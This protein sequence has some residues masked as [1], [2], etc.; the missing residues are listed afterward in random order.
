MNQTEDYNNNNKIV[1]TLLPIFTDFDGKFKGRLSSVIPARITNTSENAPIS[2]KYDCRIKVEYHKDIM[3]L[4]EEGMVIAIRNFKGK[5]DN[6][7]TII[8]ETNKSKPVDRFTLLVISRIWPDHYGIRGLA[9]STYYPMQFEV[10]EQ[11]V[12]DWDTDDKATMMIQLSTIPINYDLIFYEDK[13]YEFVKGF[14]YPIIADEVFLLHSDTIRDM[15]NKKIIEQLENKLTNTKK[16]EDVVLKVADQ[17][18]GIIKMFENSKEKIPIY[19]N[20]DNMIRYHFGIFSFTGGGKSNLLSNLLRKILLGTEDTKIVIFDISCEYPFLLMDIFN[21]PNIKSQIILESE[22]K[23]SEQFDICVVKPR[24]YED[25]N[26]V[27]IALSKVYERGIVSHF[28]KP[29]DITPTYKQIVDELNELKAEGSGKPH[30]ISAIS[31][32]YKTIV[33]F[34]S[35]NELDEKDFINLEFVQLMS[36]EAVNIMKKYH[37]HDKSTIYGWALSLQNLINNIKEAKEEEKKD[38]GFTT[39]EIVDTI[40]GDSRLICISISDPYKIKELAI[41]ISR[42]MLRKRKRQFK[43]RPYVLFVFDEAQEFIQDLSNSKGIDKECSQEIETLLRQGRK[44]GLGGCIATQR[45]AYLNTSA[46]QQLHTYF[47]GTLP[48]PYDR[49]VVSST[50]TIDQG[51]L[52]K[53]LEFAPGDWLLSSYIA[54]GIENI[55]I[56]IQAENSEKTLEKFL[57]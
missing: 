9:D 22:V 39:D 45:I 16:G 30:Y 17:N 46:L 14:S 19:V 35:Q 49:N 10:I 31:E 13:S 36:T 34:I 12:I 38:R 52:E 1:K 42:E 21:N 41:S 55:P 25:N 11:S 43:V 20:Y 33:K 44:Y 7:T 4:L 51:I 53:T 15:Y 5:L 54:T 6:S 2:A 29:Q 18:I 26:S 50:F 47:V 56:F 57:I 27:K 40:N 24:D 8:S 23:N 37:V 32:I 28:V 3:S 48:R